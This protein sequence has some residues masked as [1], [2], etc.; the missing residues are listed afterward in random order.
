MLKKEEK[1]NQRIK[2][3]NN[4][5]NSLPTY[6]YKD[7]EQLSANQIFEKIADILNSPFKTGNKEIRNMSNKVEELN[8]LLKTIN[9]NLPLSE[10]VKNVLLT[11]EIITK[12]S[13]FYQYKNEKAELFEYI[14]SEYIRKVGNGDNTAITTG[15]WG[16]IS[17]Y[18]RQL[19]TDVFIFLEMNKKQ[20]ISGSISTFEKTGNWQHDINRAKSAPRTSIS[21]DLPDFIKTMDKLN[22]QSQLSISI[23][24]ELSDSLDIVSSLK[25]QAKSGINQSIL[26]ISTRNQISLNNLEENNTLKLLQDLYNLDSKN[27]FLFFYKTPQ[28]SKNLTSY[29]N[30]LLSKNITKTN[31]IKS[32]DIYFTEKGLQTAYQWIENKNVYLK[33]LKDIKLNSML[34]TQE[35]KYGFSSLTN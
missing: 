32:N 33:F 24:D 8:L 5:I 21:S 20:K 6:N 31:L 15:S 30:Y 22:G 13:G 17:D 11:N 19:I 26:N 25:A 34:L 29:G 2:N 1:I 10:K 4:F 27:N 23:D 16:K 35:R 9:V 3:A 28:K 7:T 14:L 12:D 18:N